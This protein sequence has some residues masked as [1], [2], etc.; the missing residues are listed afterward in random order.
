MLKGNDMNRQQI[1]ETIASLAM[2]Q[3]FYGRLM[4]GFYGDY[5]EILDWLAN[6]VKPSCPLDVV[7]AIE[8]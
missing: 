6:E 8:E 4:A 7:L 1:H 2:S 5:D 3:G